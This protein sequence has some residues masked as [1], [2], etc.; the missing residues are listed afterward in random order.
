MIFGVEGEK[1]DNNRSRKLGGRYSSNTYNVNKM[2]MQMHRGAEA[3]K[4]VCDRLVL[5]AAS[6]A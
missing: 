4:P 1:N 5:M 6:R 3:A 2:Q